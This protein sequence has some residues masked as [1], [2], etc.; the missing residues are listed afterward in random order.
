MRQDSA[1]AAKLF[2][3][4]DLHQQ[5]ALGKDE[6]TALLTEH[7]GITVHPETLEKVW[8]SFDV[9]A[10]GTIDASE[11]A[12]LFSVM[13]RYVDEFTREKAAEHV[14][15]QSPSTGKAG[16]KKGSGALQPAAAGAVRV[17]ALGR[18][19]DMSE[20][21]DG[22]VAALES[23][24]QM[25]SAAVGMRKKQLSEK[26]LQAQLHEHKEVMVQE[27][28]QSHAELNS[29]LK[30][31]D[32]TISGLKQQLDGVTSS[33]T[34]LSNQHRALSAQHQQSTSTH[35]Q[36]LQQWQQ[37]DLAHQAAVQQL[38]AAM[39]AQAESAAELV[40]RTARME[41]HMTQKAGCCGSRPPLEVGAAPKGRVSLFGL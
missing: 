6:V 39:R 5:L 23:Q 37:Q 30:E 3:K 10:S 14:R 1:N 2:A 31:R 20:L 19:V 13:R 27:L 29:Q 34:Q 21:D 15:E 4:L 25:L 35:E 24:L 32:Q 33:L 18:E 36:S 8:E 17:N 22:E 41:M 9:D 40:G 7:M 38:D 28:R 12:V 11:F 16:N 26:Q